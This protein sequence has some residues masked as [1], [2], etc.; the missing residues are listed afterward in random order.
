MQYFADY[1]SKRI[2]WI[3][4]KLH[5][6]GT[7]AM[8]GS[9]RKFVVVN[10]SEISRPF[11]ISVFEDSLYWTDWNTNSIKSVNKKT[12]RS[13]QTLSLGS[14]SVMDIKVYHEM[15]QERRKLTG[16]L[17]SF[18]NESLMQKSGLYILTLE[19]SS[20]ADIL[21]LSLEIFI[22]RIVL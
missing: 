1:I 18:Y 12:G 14:Y 10:P 3:D 6:I 16:F 2:Y 8:D 19:G 4:A 11:S 5:K 17:L 13:L 9:D 21:F 22:L 7:T 15:R 20:Q